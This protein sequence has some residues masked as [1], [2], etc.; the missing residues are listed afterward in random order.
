MKGEKGA[1]GMPESE[2]SGILELYGEAVPQQF[3]RQME[4]DLEL[5][6]RRRVFNLPL[7]VW[8]MI[9]QRLD[10]KATLSTAVQQ[11]A[12]QRP[13]ILLT[14]HKRNRE[15]TVSCHTGAYS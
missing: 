15:G 5:Q 11:V 1:P 4:R 10:V 13:Q 9:A 2:L 12:Q 14:D 7:V 8:L 6:A 3:F